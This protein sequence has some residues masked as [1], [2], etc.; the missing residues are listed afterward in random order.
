MYPLKPKS[1]KKEK[2]MTPEDRIRWLLNF[3]EVQAKINPE[4]KK[5]E[6]Y[7]LERK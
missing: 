2:E 4:P 1:Q 5:S 7:P 3:I 6:G